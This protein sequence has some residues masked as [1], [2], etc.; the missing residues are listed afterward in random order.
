MW[1]F[2][3]EDECQHKYNGHHHDKMPEDGYSSTWD[4]ADQSDFQSTAAASYTRPS[5]RSLDVD[6]ASSSHPL[7]ISPQS[8]PSSDSLGPSS[9]SKWRDTPTAISESHETVP[10]DTA[11][12]VEQGFDENVLRALCDM[13]VC[14]PFSS[15]SHIPTELR[16]LQCGVPL[17]LDRI[18]QSMVSCRASRLR[19]HIVL[20]LMLYRR[21]QC[22]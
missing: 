22:S 14:C 13:D 21:L 12:L 10:G 11:S 4:S 19:L 18:K 1:Q 15:H 9:T 16:C 8:R 3:F 2:V 17:L 5:M 6:S 7:S 20:I